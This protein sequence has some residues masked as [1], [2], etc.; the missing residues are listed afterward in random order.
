[1]KNQLFLRGWKPTIKSFFIRLKINCKV[2]FEL[3]IQEVFIK[4]CVSQDVAD[5]HFDKIHD[6]IETYL[7]TKG[8]KDVLEKLLIPQVQDKERNKVPIWICWWQGE[9]AMPEIVKICYQRVLEFA[10]SH[11]VHLI[12]I[13]N[14]EKYV[15]ISSTTISKYKN[16]LLLPAHLADLLRLKLLDAYGGLWLDATIFLSR[17]LEENVFDYDFYSLSNDC[18]NHISVSNFRW[19]SFVLGC[20][21]GN[22]LVHSLAVT[23]EKYIEQENFFIHY[24][25][26][27]YFIDMLYKHNGYVKKI[28]DNLPDGGKYLHILRELY[29]LPFDKKM[30]DSILAETEYF[31]LTYKENLVEKTQDGLETYYFHIKKLK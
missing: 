13:D 20:K 25:V 18:K 11:P 26:I 8:Y 19:C 22:P 21:K 30:F 14:Y 23:F 10:G 3:F 15:N 24:L 29:P 12:T 28:I 9:E 16:K 17:P 7:E 4:F 1:M 6:I 5:K 31:K 27:D 2:A